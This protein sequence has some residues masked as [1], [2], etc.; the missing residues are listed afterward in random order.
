MPSIEDFNYN[1]S[2]SQEYLERKAIISD[3]KNSDS[4][5]SCCLDPSECEIR[6]PNAATPDPNSIYACLHVLNPLQI[7]IDF[8]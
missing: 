4:S 5:S 8:D 6:Y 1:S 2:D 3:V 7:I